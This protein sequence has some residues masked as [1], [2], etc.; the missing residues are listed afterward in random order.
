MR[1]FKPAPLALELVR[2]P[3]QQAKSLTLLA[4]YATEQV[5]SQKV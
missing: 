4:K 1:L 3:T 2:R 5:N